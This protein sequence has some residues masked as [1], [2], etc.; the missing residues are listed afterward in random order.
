MP[1]NKGLK[2]RSVL[3]DAS[4]LSI[5]CAF[6]MLSKIHSFLLKSTMIIRSHSNNLRHH[7]NPSTVRPSIAFRRVLRK[8]NGS[9]QNPEP[10]K[11]N[12]DRNDRTQNSA[13]SVPA[14]TSLKQFDKK[15][16]S[17]DQGKKF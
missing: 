9:E 8:G 2:F 16:S 1:E 13:G 4:K 15:Y 17:T 14:R 5:D 7:Q 3:M 6:N 11:K 10:I 12:N